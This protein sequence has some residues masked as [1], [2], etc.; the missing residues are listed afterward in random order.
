MK[1]I[2]VY[3]WKGISIPLN[4]IYNLNVMLYE[5]DVVMLENNGAELWCSV[6]KLY[7][8]GRQYCN[9]KV[10]TSKT[11]VIVHYWKFPVW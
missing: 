5:D 10:S 4:N 1:S 7:E 3:T 2:K 11:N 9:L 6:Y 8:L